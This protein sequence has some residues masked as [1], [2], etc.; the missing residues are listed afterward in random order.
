MLAKFVGK[1]PESYAYFSGDLITMRSYIAL[2]DVY[3]LSLR[4]AASVNIA[5]NSFTVAAI[6]SVWNRWATSIMGSLFRNRDSRP[7]IISSVE[8]LG[9]FTNDSLAQSNASARRDV[10]IALM[11]SFGGSSCRV[12]RKRAFTAQ[13]VTSSSVALLKIG[14]LFLVFVAML[15]NMSLFKPS[16]IKSV[17]RFLICNYYVSYDTFNKYFGL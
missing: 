4:Y 5:K 16:F 15:N 12:G 3:P 8:V 2:R 1:L 10:Y 9:F 7:L 17:K 6:S 14:I 13:E 11:A